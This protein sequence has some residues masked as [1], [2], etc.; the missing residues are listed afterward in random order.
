M[1]LDREAC[2]EV[3]S[4]KRQNRFFNQRD[5]VLAASGFVGG[6]AGATSVSREPSL[7]TGYRSKDPRNGK[8]AA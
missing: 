5:A 1:V 3:C 4:K 2:V 7:S 6:E 8:N